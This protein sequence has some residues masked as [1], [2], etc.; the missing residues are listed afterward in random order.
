MIHI[1]PIIF[2]LDGG[3][4]LRLNKYIIIFTVL[5]SLGFSQTS[6]ETAYIKYFK[7]DL[8]FL[9]DITMM[10]TDRHQQSHLIV[11]YNEDNLPI[12]IVHVSASHDTLKR[13]VLT[14]TS[15]HLLK[16]KICYDSE[17]TL[18]KIVQFGSDEPWSQAFRYTM[19]QAS[20]K[21][22]FSGQQTQFLFYPTGKLHR[23]DFYLIDGTSYG[24]ILFIYESTGMIMEEVW[25][26]LPSH[27]VLRRFVYETVTPPKIRQVWEYNRQD[28]LVSHVALEMAPEDQL[29]HQDFPKSG[30]ILDEAQIILDDLRDSRVVSLIPERIPQTVWDVMVLNTGE[31]LEIEYLGQNEHGFIIRMRNDESVLTIPSATIKTITSKWGENIFPGN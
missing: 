24:Q 28:S 17:K 23:I 20:Q 8:D 12:F 29:Y 31:V 18:V 21:G 26:E 5:F 30:N 10:A 4:A 1:F 15:E 19:E 14:H 6:Q 7:N 16:Q 13:E 2:R 9:S 3:L 25:K 22:Y 27:V 11:S